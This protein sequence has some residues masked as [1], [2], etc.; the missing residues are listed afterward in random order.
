MGPK[1]N[2]DPEDR[3]A[4][5]RERRTSLLDRRNA[6]ESNAGGLTNDLR[7]VYGISSLFNFGAPGTKP[8][9][10]SAKKSAPRTSSP[11]PSMFK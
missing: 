7:A 3:K 8:A 1:N 6:A 10:T 5:L 2:E 4:R 11:T 9:S